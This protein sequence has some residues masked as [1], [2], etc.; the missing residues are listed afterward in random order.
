V[1]GIVRVGNPSVQ[2]VRTVDLLAVG[3]GLEVDGASLFENDAT[4]MNSV[5]ASEVVHPTGLAIYVDTAAAETDGGALSLAG[6]AGGPAGTDSDGENGGT[7]IITGGAGSALAGGGTN[8]GSGGDVILTGGAAGGATGTA[9]SGIVRVG[10]PIVGSTRTADL[11]A[12]G[13]GLEVDGTARFDGGISS[14]SSA[15]MTTVVTVRDDAG[16]GTCTMTFTSGLLTATT[17]SHT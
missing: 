7:T 14:G 4:F 16:T 10:T 17:C 15:G 9:V 1:D 5:V 12:V 11:L 6:G 3:G 13:G 2:S 8:D